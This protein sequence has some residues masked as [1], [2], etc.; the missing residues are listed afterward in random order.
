M[1]KATPVV[2]FFGVVALCAG[3]YVACDKGEPTKPEPKLEFPVKM[4][5]GDPVGQWRAD[6]ATIHLVDSSLLALMHSFGVYAFTHEEKL[7][8]RLTIGQ[9]NSYS[10][11]CTLGVQATVWFGTKPDSLTPMLYT[12]GD[13]L[14]KNGVVGRQLPNALIFDFGHTN[15]RLDTLGYTATANQLKL[16]TLPS[17]LPFM[18]TSI[19][20]YFMLYFSK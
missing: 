5:G 15:F 7:R 1:R 16:V 19:A 12:G 13:T 4:L 2:V 8:G 11:A 3:L 9:D 17:A 6:S 18:G 14:V 10:A 20:I